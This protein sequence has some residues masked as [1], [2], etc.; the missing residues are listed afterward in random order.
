MRKINKALWIFS[1]MVVAWPRAKAQF[2]M[3]ALKLAP[4]TCLD[5]KNSGK[6]QTDGTYTVYPNGVTSLSVYCDMTGDGGGW[7]LVAATDSTGVT[8]V[9]S[10]LPSSS[11]IGLLDNTM[12]PA[13]ANGATTVR[14]LIPFHGVN[15]R[16]VSSN[17][18][19]R[20]RAYQNVSIDSNMS[21]P[22]ADWS[23]GP[24]QLTYICNPGAVSLTISIYH[25][26]G[27]PNGMHWKPE[28]SAAKWDSAAGPAV[29]MTLWVK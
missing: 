7:T 29:S 19:N 28:W 20:L 24:S 18:I 3:P 2:P 11:S 8:A 16:S 22:T 26:C 1:L 21:N 23:S 27:N 12:L 10:S 4:R 6:G 9:T 25:A 17:P 15:I 5:L 13:L 14:L